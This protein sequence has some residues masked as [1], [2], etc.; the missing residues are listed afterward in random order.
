MAAISIP[1]PLPQR[2]QKIPISPIR[3]IS[4]IGPIGPIKKLSQPTAQQ[5]AR[6]PLR[7]RSTRI[8]NPLADAPPHHASPISIPNTTRTTAHRSFAVMLQG[9]TFG[10][11]TYYIALNPAQLRKSGVVMIRSTHFGVPL[12][13]GSVSEPFPCNPFYPWSQLLHASLLMNCGSKQPAT[14]SGVAIIY[15]SS[16]SG[17]VADTPVGSIP[18][19][20]QLPPPPGWRKC[21][22]LVI[23]VA[24][25]QRRSGGRNAAPID[26]HYATSR[27]EVRSAGGASGSEP[28]PF[29]PFYP[30]S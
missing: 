8:L 15:V 29:Y 10:T 9:R 16:P 27:A 24:L 28:F 7:H 20:A 12:S 22:P 14:A 25:G 5:S 23:I 4:P 19:Y 1:A 13:V 21:P 3:P 17:H 30:C 2:P 18:G 11:H 26:S 6:P